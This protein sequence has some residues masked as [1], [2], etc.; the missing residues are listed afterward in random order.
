MLNKNP[1]MIGIRGA[2]NRERQMD[3]FEQ[4]LKT[5]PKE[6]EPT[7][8][9]M[10]ADGYSGEERIWSAEQQRWQITGRCEFNLPPQ[11]GESFTKTV[12]NDRQIVWSPKELRW[13]N[14][15]DRRLEK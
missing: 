11:S 12:K 10:N 15:G 7:T 13:F 6:G 2:I 1:E 14:K 5:P 3:G 9:W 4:V 8:I